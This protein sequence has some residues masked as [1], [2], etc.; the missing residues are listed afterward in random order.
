MA[1][2][3]CTIVIIYVYAHSLSHT[4]RNAA[5]IKDKVNQTVERK[6]TRKR[7]KNKYT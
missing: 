4:Y 3:Q 5:A 7:G 6:Q 2:A 1:F